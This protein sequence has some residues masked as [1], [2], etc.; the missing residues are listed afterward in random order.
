[1][2]VPARFERAIPDLQSGALTAWPR[3]RMAPGRGF[4]P[5]PTGSK[6][7]VLPLHQP[8]M[9]PDRGFEPRPPES[10]SG[11]LPLHQSGFLVP[12]KGFEPLIL[13]AVG[14]KPT[15]Y[16]DS[17]TQAGWSGRSDLN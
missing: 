15:V 9:A 3:N 17:T 6:P 13:P 11:V 5:L 2:E 16:A 1:M 7:I 10:E 4:E 12:V 8:G 14:F